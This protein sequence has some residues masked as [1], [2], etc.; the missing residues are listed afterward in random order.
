[1]TISS[2]WTPPKKAAPPTSGAQFARRRDGAACAATETTAA[3]CL[4]GTLQSGGWLAASS[5]PARK[6][7]LRKGSSIRLEIRRISIRIRDIMELILTD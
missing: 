6:A 4:P 1:M 2:R 5:A 7:V 3:S